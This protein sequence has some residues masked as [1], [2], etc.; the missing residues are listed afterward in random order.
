[1]FTREEL[2]GGM[3]ARRASTLLFAI[4]GETARQVA[5]SRI[6]RAG[7]VGERT[8]AER[9]QDFLKAIATGSKLPKPPSVGDLERFASGWANLVPAADDLRAGVGRLLGTKYRF[10]RDDVPGIRRALALDSPTVAA[11][12]ERHYH[13]PLESI[14]VTKLPVRTRARWTLSRIVARFDRLPPFWIAFFLALTETLGEGILSLPLALAGL[15]PIPG[16]ILLLVLGAVNLITMGA[17]AEAVIRNGSMRYGAAYFGR[18][19]TELIGRAPASV[20]GVVFALDGVLAFLFYFLGF[21]SVLAGATGI[22]VGFWIAVLFG[23]NVFM[24]RNESLDD[25]IASATIIGTLSLLLI[26]AI[27]VIALANVDPANLAYANVPVLNGQPIDGP[28]FGLIFGIILM[29]F[30]GHTSA[31]NAAKLL[32]TIEPSG[33][34]LLWGNLLAMT[35]VILL[36]CV[37]S[38]AILGVL[39]PVPLLGTNGTA[40]TPLAEALGPAVNVMSVIYVV[41]A[42]GIGSLYVTLGMYN[43]VVEFLPRRSNGAGGLLARLGATR[44]GRLIAGFAP[45]ALVCLALEVVVLAGLDDFAATIGVAGTLT[46]PILTGIFPMLLILAARRKGEYVPGRVIGLLGHPVT[47]A[48]LLTLYTLAVGIHVLIWDGPVLRVAALGAAIVIIGLIAWTVRGRVFRTRAVVELRVDH[49][50]RRSTVSVTGAGHEF[51]LDQ[52]IQPGP[53]GEVAVATLPA[54]PWREL[55]IWAHAVTTDG[56]SVGLPAEVEIVT[57][58]GQIDTR[59]LAPSPDPIVVPSDGRPATI[60][61]QI[62]GARDER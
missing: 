17:M 40:M 41:L 10:R 15:G 54:G 33:R 8:T 3:P 2:L 13:Q 53:P 43:Q 5:A 7:Y 56:W 52:S 45:A 58:G 21:G 62:E 34:S 27:T 38:V 4:E 55:R 6:N 18:L 61:I 50:F 46:V 19:V 29:A 30:F 35:T 60:R 59:A 20:L 57:D 48:I 9:E 24:L 11:S 49:R 12:F 42:I 16:V 14:F 22:P 31:A 47:V 1:M 32:L 23:L 39:G 25:T 36:Y 28:I 51:A 44:R 37:A 26:V